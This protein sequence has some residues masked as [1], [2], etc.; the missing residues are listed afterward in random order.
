MTNEE[1]YEALDK[2]KAIITLEEYEDL[3]DRISIDKTTEVKLLLF[4]VYCLIKDHR[5]Q[6]SPAY[7]SEGYLAY[8]LITRIK[9]V[10]KEVFDESI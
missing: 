6:P 7:Y 9:D 1:L 8:D 3:R 2:P 5:L 10:F 4:D